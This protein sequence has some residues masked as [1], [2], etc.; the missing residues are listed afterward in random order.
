MASV[1]SVWVVSRITDPWI[2][3]ALAR[4]ALAE[5]ELTLK[6]YPPGSITAGLDR[7]WGTAEKQVG[8]LST[9]I[10]GQ[11]FYQLFLAELPSVED[12]VQG[13]QRFVHS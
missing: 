9:D 13:V 3:R 4:R 12:W 11:A 5:L 10:R 8:V 1:A 2:S 7:A 6:G